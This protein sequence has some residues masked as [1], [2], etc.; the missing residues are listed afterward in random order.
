MPCRRRADARRA[1]AIFA[2]AAAAR[3]A[4]LCVYEA[5]V[6]MEQIK[7]LTTFGLDGGFEY[8]IYDDDKHSYCMYIL[9]I[10]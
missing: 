8:V 5:V 7:A 10:V 2:R 3:R 4:E 6:G 1:H 9:H